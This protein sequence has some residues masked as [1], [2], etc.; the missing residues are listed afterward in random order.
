MQWSQL[1]MRADTLILLMTTL[2]QL[3]LIPGQL[4][5]G[6][7]AEP[8][9]IEVTAYFG[10]QLPPGPGA[11]VCLTGF[12]GTIGKVKNVH[13]VAGHEAGHDLWETLIAIEKRHAPKIPADSVAFLKLFPVT[14]TCTASSE[15]FIEIDTTLSAAALGW[16]KKT[17]YVCGAKNGCNPA[18]SGPPIGDRAVL[19][20]EVY[21]SAEVGYMVPPPWWRKAIQWAV[22][23]VLIVGAAL[24]IVLA[25]RRVRPP[26][27]PN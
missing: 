22:Y 3:L 13:L 12:A 7:P 8:D 15:P 26:S 14:G 25:G 9:N 5:A 23:P 21:Y 11:P 20:A 24:V 4:Q 16:G 19:K 18:P 10:T 2:P 1:Q 17:G 6:T 27:K